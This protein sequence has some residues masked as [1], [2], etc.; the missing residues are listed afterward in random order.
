MERILRR[1]TAVHRDEKGFALVTA[2]VLL[3]VMSLLMLVT[4][5]ASESANRL[6]ERGSRWTKTLG[7]A[8]AGLNDA[9]VHLSASLSSAASVTGCA[10]NGTNTTGCA[11]PGGEYQVAWS[12]QGRGKLVIQAYGF[13]PTVAAYLSHQQN[14]LARRVRVTLAPPRMFEYAL[15][16]ATTLEV[17]NGSTV[18]GDIFANEKITVG[19]NAIVCGSIDNATLGVDMGNGSMVV[20]SL[21]GYDCENEATVTAGGSITMGS[22]GEIDGDAV[23]SAPTETDCPPVPDAYY[24]SGGT[25]HGSATA[26]GSVSTSTTSAHPNTKTSP[27]TTRSLPDYSFDSANYTS[28]T[29][30]PS[31]TS[32]SE[33]TTSATAVSAFNSGVSKTGM[34]GTYAIWQTQPTQSTKVNLESLTLSGDTTIITNAPIDLGNTGEI[35]T[36]SSGSL[37]VVISLY[38]PPTGTTCSDKGGECSIYGKNAV[39]LDSGDPADPDDGVYALFYTP[40]KMAFKNNGNQGEGALWAGAL[41]MKNG[42]DIIYNANVERVTGFGGSIEQTL[43]EE[44]SAG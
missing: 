44:L 43:W 3:A 23:A 14:S 4:L 39:V 28:L 36:S 31:G 5:S 20:D 24:I 16:S 11:V 7:V 8:E 22:G 33:D 41:D 13:Y 25:V 42:F 15:F 12:R 26:C 6:S 18:I 32:C 37:L 40:G 19:N 30:Y 38:V 21:S 10:Y 35:T 27:P 29:C 17:K 2:L 34:S 1:L 9:I